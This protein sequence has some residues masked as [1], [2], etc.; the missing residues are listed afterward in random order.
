MTFN[1]VIILLYGDVNYFIP[2]NKFDVNLFTASSK[3]IGNILRPYVSNGYAIR[4]L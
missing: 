4:I 2:L 3:C 1:R